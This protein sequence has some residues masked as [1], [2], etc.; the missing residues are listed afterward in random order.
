VNALLVLVVLPAL[1]G[2]AAEALFREP[3]KASLAA[4]IGAAALTCVAV[5][6]LDLRAAWNWIAA[7]LVS[8][9]CIAIAVAATL[10][11]DGSLHSRRRRFLNGS[12]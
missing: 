1:I 6:L 3:R 8:P 10:I 11:C 4:A 7:L 9:L 5:Q 2:V 12:H